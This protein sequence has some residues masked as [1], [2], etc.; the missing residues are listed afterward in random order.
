MDRKTYM[1]LIQNE[2]ELRPTGG[3]LTA[4]GLLKIENG[5]IISLTFESSDLVDD[6]SKAYPKAPWQL[7]EYMK[8]EILLFRDAN[9][10]T[11]FPTTVEWTKFLYSYTRAK[12]VDGVIAIDQH[13]VKELLQIVGP[14]KVIGVDEPISAN[15]VL[16]YM[17]TAKQNTP[18]SGVSRDDWNRKQFISWLAE[19]LINRLLSIDSKTWPSLLRAIMQLL[20]EKHI[21]LQINDPEISSL[22]TQRGWDGAVRPKANSDFL[23]VV[24]SN[25]ALI[26]QTH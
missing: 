5:K 22:I 21:L 6:L 15:N 3:F 24:D 20:D 8:A 10:F 26:K 13:M 11:N 4:V 18:P 25:V 2:D 1:I 16:A 7:D 19:P 9:W 12:T 17:R 23:M 14:I